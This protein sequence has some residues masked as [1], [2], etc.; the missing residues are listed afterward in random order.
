MSKSAVS[1]TKK[2]KKA[3]TARAA[4]S[5]I[6]EKPLI[7][8]P[9]QDLAAL[10]TIGVL[11]LLFF[12][13][14]LFGGKIFITPDNT[15]SLS[16]QTY[17][18]EAIEQ[19]VF[20]QWIPY[21]FSGMPSYGSLTTTGDRAFDV[22]NILWG[23]FLQF[24]TAPSSNDISDW[25]IVYFFIYSAGIYTLLRIKKA[26]PFAAMVGALGGTFATLSLV[27]VP[28]GHNTKMIAISMLPFTLVFLE[29]LREEHDWKKNIFNLAALAFVLNLQVRSTHVQMVYYAYL[30]VGIYFLFELISALV[31]KESLQAWLRS[32]AGFVIAVA[33]GLSMSA[34]TYLSVAEYTPHS[35][36]GSASITEVVPELSL[37]SSPDAKK[38]PAGSGLDYDY[39]TSWSFGVSEVL[40][41]FIPYY[42]GYGNNTYW[43]PQPFTACPQ[44]FGATIL[45]LALFGLIYYR[46][47][48]FVQALGVIGTIA[49]LISFGKYLPI[50]FD[51]LF[52]FLPFFNKFRAPSMI[53]I[54]LQTSAC[55][56][57]GY[58]IKA[59]YDLRQT[60]PEKA[61][62]ALQYMALG[63]VILLFVAMIGI[64]SYEPVYLKEYAASPRGQM[65]IKQ[66]PGV[67][68]VIKIISD[69]YRLFDKVKTD[70]V[71]S[72]FFVSV[73]F[74]G[75]YFFARRR[76][77]AAI[78]VPLVVITVVL[79][80]WRASTD[81]LKD[82][83]DAQE[84]KAFFAKPD[85]I[86]FLEKDKSKFRINPHDFNKEPNWLAYFKMESVGGYQGAKLRL[87]Q[88]LIETV[89][90]GSTETPFF[91]VNP[92]MTDLLNIKYI[93]S[94]TPYSVVGFKPVFNGSAFV[95]EREN[96]TPRLWF[97]KEVQQATNVEAL[98]HIIAQ[99][100]NPRERAYIEREVP[101][102]DPADST[103]QVEITRY[104]IQDIEIKATATGNHF[105]FISEIYYPSWKCYI[106][107]QETEIYKTNYA[108][109][110]IVVPKGTHEIRLVY[111]SRAFEIGKA[112]SIGANV[113][114]I[115]MF[116]FAGFTAWQRR[117]ALETV[118]ASG[119]STPDGS[120]AAK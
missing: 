17:I 98:K 89:G 47:E 9:Y 117:R 86:E 83:K 51:P 95:L 8:E 93:V 14:A 53:L 13:E 96:P 44:F 115:G 64:S 60:Q 10:L 33:I 11:L 78:F 42:Y 38:K 87:Y 3:E 21:I 7:A 69:E 91:F 107:G 48:H 108:F 88:D 56:L 85:F 111:E 22:L 16:L 2:A 90:M 110:G 45:V 34:D 31:R 35:I 36:R 104:G 57:A 39:A 103:A 52:Y 75:G 84:Q 66:N 23:K 40:T 77:Q 68:N 65:L 20:P 41:F 94:S 61:M 30:A 92:V 55:I 80:L 6:E 28:V 116:G 18:N 1:G 105:L 59:L 112:L 81:L 71:L 19:G 119:A 120:D 102:L 58:G 101:A 106:D 26:T 24:I 70:V 79:D 82:L 72:L 49:L 5:P 25:V 32:V 76:L 54:L 97:V 12:W 15:A 62:K 67:P 63:A 109:R 50:L 43:G 74:V 99:D 29:R 113:L 100:F 37:P 73:V 114:L 27:W 118:A 4:K 46:R